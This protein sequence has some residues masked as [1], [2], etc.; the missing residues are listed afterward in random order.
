MVAAVLWVVVVLVLPLVLPFVIGRLT[1]SGGAGAAAALVGFA[2][3]CYWDWRRVSPRPGHVSR[4]TEAAAPA[5]S[6]L[7]RPLEH[8]ARL[9][10]NEPTLSARTPRPKAAG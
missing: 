8:L 1:G 2:A 9:A 6:E 10:S 4:L 7:I 3:G 5:L